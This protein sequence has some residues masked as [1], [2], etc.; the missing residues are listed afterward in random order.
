[1][2]IKQQ[3]QLSLFNHFK[4]HWIFTTF[5]FDWI[6]A[7][8]KKK[9]KGKIYYSK[10]TY[11]Y[12]SNTALQK[13]PLMCVVYTPLNAPYWMD[14]KNLVWV[15]ICSWESN[16][17][18]DWVR[19]NLLPTFRRSLEWLKDY[20]ARQGRAARNRSSS[21]FAIDTIF[22]PIIVHAFSLH[23]PSHISNCVPCSNSLLITPDS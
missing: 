15:R 14:L 10:T 16:G 18:D 2:N 6:D 11:S 21:T 17:Y 23:Q 4:M 5:E 22:M 1:M 9:Y 7:N 20:K 12:L 8:P 3:W 19:P 13:N